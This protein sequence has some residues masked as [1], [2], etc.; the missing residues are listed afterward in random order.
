[1]RLILIGD[2][3]S[4]RTDYLKKAA[5][6]FHIPVEVIG[7][8]TLNRGFSI[9]ESINEPKHTAVKIDPPAY[10]TVHLSD[11][12]CLL[13]GYKKALE[14]LAEADCQFLNAPQAVWQ[15]LDK[16][17]TKICLQNHKLPVTQMFTERSRTPEALLEQM[18][19]R[20]CFSV[21][22]KP[23][24]FSG[25]AGVA[26]FR[27]HPIHKDMILYTSCRREHTELINTKKLCKLT[28]HREI[29]EILRHLLAL[30]CIIER[31]HPKA[32]Y[33]G[34]SYDLRVVYQFGHIAHMVVR[35]S[36][37]P[38]TNLHL[39]NQ[40]LDVK[41]LGLDY[42]CIHNIEKVCHDAVSCFPKLQMAGIDILLEKDT[43]RPLIIE[44][45]GQGDLIY[46]DIYGKNNIYR[47]QV[48]QLCRL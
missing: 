18:R 37:G 30:G 34:K 32:D 25:A 44:M 8:D 12:Q 1:M 17:D 35:R 45:N 26:A 2:E 13:Q 24:Y 15:L 29:M 7:W 28:D 46:Q 40:A 20:R 31:W 21:F 4:K 5:D 11:M 14:K 9:K 19:Q 33:R 41:S 43:L 39:N 3:N 27:I 36:D 16:K 47:E 22:I 48:R 10:Q 42:E 23:R 6:E 38:I